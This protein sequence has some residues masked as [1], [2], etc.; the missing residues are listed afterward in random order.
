MTNRL[1]SYLDSE[2]GLAFDRRGL[3]SLSPASMARSVR[4][5]WRGL[6]DAWATQP[7]LRLHAGMA[8]CIF[9]VGCL[10]RVTITGWLWLVLA[11]GLVIAAE[12]LHAAIEQLVDLVVGTEWHPLARQIK[13]TAAGFVLV[14]AVMAAVITWLIV[15]PR[16]LHAS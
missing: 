7:N 14:T 11:I 9:F 10:A 8:V 4:G 1:Q 5:A 6:S 3:T 16:L 15:L 12:V 13:D 2:P